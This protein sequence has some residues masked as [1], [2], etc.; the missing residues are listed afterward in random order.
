MTPKDR[1]AKE[2]V[3]AEAAF[4]LLAEKGFS[5]VTMLAV[6]R[7]AKSSN[8]TLYRWYG[9]KTG[10]FAMLVA[11]HCS[12]CS[13]KLA[14]LPETRNDTALIEV[15][16]RLLAVALDPRSIAL[17]RAAA[18][19][20]SNRLGALLEDRRRAAIHPHIQLFFEGMAAA[21]HIR[22][23]PRGAAELWLE[24]LLGDWV[25]RCAMG[26]V[27]PSQATFH[28]RAALAAARLIVLCG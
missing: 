8:E 5:G 21:G 9:D 2:D 27:R 28:S 24:L 13:A 25:M 26:T 11:R 4:G 20:A 12:Q 16:E 23:D 22:A 6:A 19:D 15:G 17:H 7:R 3:I 18:A 10:L 1:T 14:N